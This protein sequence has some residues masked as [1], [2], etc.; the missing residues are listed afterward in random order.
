MRSRSRPY[1]AARPQESGGEG[2]LRFGTMTDRRLLLVH[3]HPDDETI[4]TGI[5]M[6]AMYMVLKRL[7]VFPL[8]ASAI[9]IIFS[10]VISW[11]V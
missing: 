3:A 10:I 5:A 1:G 7:P 4:G 2:A 8:I 9:T 11:Q 6:A